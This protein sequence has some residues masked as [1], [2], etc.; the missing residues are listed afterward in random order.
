MELRFWDF[1]DVA[2]VPSC[3][4]GCFRGD[5]RTRVAGLFAAL[6]ELGGLR[7]DAGAPRALSAPP[8]PAPP[9]PPRAFREFVNPPLPIGAA[10][11]GVALSET[12]C[13]II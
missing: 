4:C 11:E 7:A 13:I 5:V 12:K 9:G 10:K 6:A 1:E 8:P 3:G 2:A